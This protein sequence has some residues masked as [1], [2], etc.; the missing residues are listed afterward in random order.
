VYLRFVD[1]AQ[2]TAFRAIRLEGI[3]YPAE[4]KGSFQSS[5]ALLNRIWETGAY[6]A[7]LCMQD[8]IWDA[9]KRDRGWWAGDLDVMG[10]VIGD[11][12]ADSALL[13]ETLTRLI[14][15][16]G[17]HVNGI[18]GYTA[19]W[20][21][22]LADLYRRSGD[23]S[24]LAEKHAALE[25]LLAQM[26]EEFD[27]AGNFLNK[28]HHWMFVDWSAGLFAFT[29]EAAEGTEL[30]FVRGYREGAWLLEE[31]GDTAGAA[32]YRVRA[33]ALAA[34]A[35]QQFADA[36][37]A[38]QRWQINAMAVLAGVASSKDYPAIWTES[39][40][41]TGKEETQIISPYFNAYVLEA[42]ARMGYRR[43]ALDWMRTYWGGMIAEGATSFWEAYDLHWPKDD[44]HRFLEADG[45]TGYFV[46]LA[47]GW[48]SGP[49]AW[50]MEQVLGIRAVESGY[51]KATIRPDLA[52]LAWIKGKV[53]TPYGVIRVEMRQRPEPRIEIELPAGIETELIAPLAH[54][55]A[56]IEVNGRDAAF[57][58]A[59]SG[60]RATLQLRGPGRFTVTSH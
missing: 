19:L 43:E 39:L 30:E 6:T 7:H 57:V 24:L 51:S 15:P 56:G 16:R 50:L 49:T 35:R 8:G 33:D 37:G 46:S 45:K 60:T 26:D 4:Y 20:I 29:P 58:P 44:P 28:G 23:R 17:Q 11:V 41:R 31:L 36:Q 54:D 18:P 9:P 25:Q 42:M 47:H 5:D 2:W 32:R 27:D 48:S 40:S 13:N 21:T 53:P 3:A 10:P 14:P 52:G 12:F 59:E 34:Q 22:A 55:G 1:G 38:G